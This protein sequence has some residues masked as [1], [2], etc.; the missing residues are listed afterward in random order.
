VNTTFII[1]VSLALGACSQNGQS[2]S[3]GSTTAA[4]SGSPSAEASDTEHEGQPAAPP[5]EEGQAEAIFA[6][7]CFW[8]VETAFEGLDGV[9]SVTSGYTG[10]HAE[11]PTYE[12]VGAHLTGHYEAVRVIYDPNETTYARLLEVFWH[13]IDPT[14][15][16]GQ[17]CDRGDS[18]RSAIFVRSDEERRLATETKEE[19]AETLGEDVATA[20]LDA[21]TFWVAEDY[22]QDFYR[23]NPT[24]YHSYRQGCGRDRRLREIWGQSAGTGGT[25]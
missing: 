7:G 14:Q 25:H 6:G 3:S 13:N 2:P 24:R 5:L 20:I 11:H 12:Q 15:E 8:C 22:H 18:Y 4:P 19:V 21:S 17:F 9:I 16:D 23:K 10:G 1:I